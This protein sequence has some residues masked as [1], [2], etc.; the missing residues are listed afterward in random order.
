MPGTLDEEFISACRSGDLDTIKSCLARGADKTICDK[1][2]KN[3]L[4]VASMKGNLE[5]FRYLLSEGF[6]PQQTSSGGNDCLHIAAVNG[7]HEIVQLIVQST[8]RVDR[9]NDAGETALM[10]LVETWPN[11]QTAKLLLERGADVN[12]QNHDGWTALAFAAHWDARWLEMTRLLIS[13]GAKLDHQTKDGWTPLLL[14]CR[15]CL[16]ANSLVPVLLEAGANIN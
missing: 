12:A 11:I 9:Q 8:D 7:H 2:G 5:I 16:V 10:R 1:Y 3:G 6:N 4:A 14:T 13:H 15:N